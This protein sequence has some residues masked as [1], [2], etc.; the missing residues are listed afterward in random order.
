MAITW[1]GVNLT[2]LANY[3]KDYPS[4]RIE[5]D[6]KVDW[7]LLDAMRPNLNTEMFIGDNV[8][9]LIKDT[10]PY[11]GKAHY[12]NADIP[13][14]GTQ[15]WAKQL[16]PL[17]EVMVNAGLT[18]QALNRAIGGDSSWG[19]VVDEVLRDQQVD[20]N[21]LLNSILIGN[22]SGA[23]ARIVS[24]A[25]S[26]NVTTITCDNTYTDSG[27]ENV[28]LLKIGQQLEIYDSG[29]TQVE[30]ASSAVQWEV[31]G[32]TFGDRANSTSTTGT[33]TVADVGG[34]L[35]GN[36]SDNDVIYIYD[37]KTSGLT[38]PMPMGLVGIVQGN[39]DD[40]A[41]AFALTTFQNLV[42]ASYSSLQGRVYQATDFATGATDGTPDDWDLTTISN[43]IKDV[44]RGTGRG[45]VSHLILGNDLAMAL[46]R[47]NWSESGINVTIANTEQGN[48]TVVGSEYAQRFRTP[49]GRVIPILVAD[50]I[51]E[52]CL[53]GITM[54]DLVWHVK[55]AFDFYRLNGQVWDKSYNDRKTNFEAP[56]G[57]YMQISANRCDNAFC[58]QDM[59]TNI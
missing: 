43:A 21:W 16:I 46:S 26:N 22:G 45:M 37:A 28:Q 53:Y 5:P 49:D 20:F 56:Y 25:Y 32:V 30:G 51:P 10:R 34:T 9:V 57:G 52:N 59:K 27:I 24:A 7:P 18:R 17:R 48:Q 39:G 55:G 14:P 29:G 54:N 58:I 36:I 8:E 42:R 15:S 31:T 3:M 4:G 38:G 2:D 40:Y 1:D 50:T 47:R 41:G 12:E 13:Y 19:T 6:E 23:V 44:E 33:I 11:T 35:Q